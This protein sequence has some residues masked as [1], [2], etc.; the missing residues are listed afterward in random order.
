M[1][2]L[3]NNL[4]KRWIKIAELIGTI[5]MMIVLTIIYLVIIPIMAI[6]VKI[7]NDP[8][9]LK[10]TSTPKWINRSQEL[11]TIEKLRNQY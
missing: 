3:F 5:N 6:P 1:K 2:L 10:S 11:F 9:K 8:L 7:I 4:W